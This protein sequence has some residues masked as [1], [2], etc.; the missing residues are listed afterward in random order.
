MTPLHDQNVQDKKG[1]ISFTF[2]Y[3]FD[4]EEIAVI[5][6]VHAAKS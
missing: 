5:L 2:H 6:L 1:I 3:E 4:G